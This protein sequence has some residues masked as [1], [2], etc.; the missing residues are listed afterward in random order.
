MRKI[1]IVFVIDSFA[2]GGGA[3]Q[4][5]LYLSLGLDKNAYEVSVCNLGVSS[6]DFIESASKG[7][8]KVFSLCQK[9]FA[10]LRCLLNL[11]RFIAREKPDILNTFLFTSDSYGRIAGI[12]N[13]VPVIIASIRNVDVW[14]KKRHIFLDRAL[15][16][17]TSHFTAN[18]RAVKEYIIKTTHVNAG[19]VTVIYNGVDTQR[20]TDKPESGMLRSSLGAEDK[21][22]ILNV[23]RFEP[24]KNHLSLLEASRAI[25]NKRSDTLFVLAGEGSIKKKIISEIKKQGLKE[26]FRILSAASH[27]ES[28]YGIADVSV[29]TSL[30]EGCPNFILESM[31]CGVPVVATSVGGVP[32][33]VEDAKTGFLV[34]VNDA[35]ALAEKILYLLDNEAHRR[36]LGEEARKKALSGFSLNQMVSGYHNLYQELLSVKGL[37]RT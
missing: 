24:E 21:K 35:P 1:R 22:I 8:V 4:Q 37:A 6:Q 5:L 23:V 28:L 15:K 30:Y 3:E 20:F 17:K 16:A 31:A 36:Q 12:L 25:L 2:F 29:L 13:K 32:E 9:G 33:L 18:A 34:P 19:R 14:K 10:D 27:I 11:S 26:Y 7:G